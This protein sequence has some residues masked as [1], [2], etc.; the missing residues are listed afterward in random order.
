MADALTLLR[1]RLGRLSLGTW[2][3]AAVLLA[4]F[5]AVLGCALLIEGF[6]RAHAERRATE[7]LRQISADFRDALDRGMAQQ[8]QQIRVLSQLEP[9]RRFDDPAGMRRALDQVQLGFNH[10]AWMGVTDAKGRVLA[11]ASGLLE[12]A[13]VSKRPWWQGALRGPFVGDVHAAVLLEKLLPEQPEPWRFV[14]FAVPIRNERGEL[15]GILGSHLSWTWARQIKSELIDAAMESHQAEALVIA[16]DGSVLLG[17][18]DMEGK[19][20]AALAPLLANPNT[21]AQLEMDGRHYFV[22]T[23]ATRGQGSYP[24]QG[25]VVLLRQ[26]AEV[27]LADYDRLRHQIGLTALALL[28][29]SVPLSWLLARRLSAPLVELAAAISARHHLGQEKMLRVGG[30]Q[31]AHLLSRALAEL[32]ARQAQQ[33]A[34]LEQRVEERTVELQMAMAQMEASERR[35]RAVTD[36]LPAMVGYFDRQERCGFSNSMGLRVHGLSESDLP[37]LTL[38][39]AIGD[40]AYAQHEPFVKQALAGRPGRFDGQ[41]P[42]NGQQ[43][44]FQANLVPDR[45]ATGH[46]LGFY[47]MTFDITP[48]K[49]AELKAARSESRLRTIADNLPVL[50]SYIDAAQRLQFLNGTFRSWLGMDPKAAEGRNIVEVI[51]PELYAERQQPLLRALAGERVSF[52]SEAQAMGQH[53]HLRTDYVPDVLEDGTVAGIYALTSDVSEA[54]AMEQ[55]LD[56]LSRMDPLT[57]CANRRQF[58]ERMAE[59]LSRS[60]RSRQPMALLFLDVDK[61]K[62]I[63]DR[64]GHAA[65]D[66]VLVEFARRLQGCVRATD[67]V[68]RLGGDEFV[69]IV[70]GM[71]EFDEAEQVARKIIAEIARPFDIAG[72]PA[73]QVSTSIGIACHPFGDGKDDTEALLARADAALYEAKAAGRNGYRVSQAPLAR[74][75]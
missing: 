28:A 69:L 51:G 70:E 48:L 20:S 3:M 65:G 42:L 4:V 52:A 59:A 64:L 2:L 60:E 19:K 46:V 50:I 30:Y 13:D 75:A 55:R 47:L 1:R 72:A 53:R 21:A 58:E 57:G 56:R 23:S 7:S 66:A 32:A 43:T 44:Y 31:E 12:G 11:S 5:V 26:P 54:K 34:L 9:F 17:P 45:D 33:D 62:S 14:D 6:A 41:L 24:G 39:Q 40:A 36:N 49:K 61:F 37:G 35:L 10:F 22:V 68:A 71:K 8:F 38:R 73:L 29:L 16:R 27:A 63:N 18:P 25:W 74:R 67:T 15:Q